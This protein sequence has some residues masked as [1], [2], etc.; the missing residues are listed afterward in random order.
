MGTERAPFI[1]VEVYSLT[2][3]YTGSL[4]A[5]KPIYIQS[6]ASGHHVPGN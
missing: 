3:D 4:E 5:V 6:S 1:Q 2:S